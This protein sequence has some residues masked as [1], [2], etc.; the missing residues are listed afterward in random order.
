MRMVI[1][2][3]AIV[4]VT[5]PVGSASAQ[6]TVGGGAFRVEVGK[7]A[8]VSPVVTRLVC[9]DPIVEPVPTAEGMTFKGLRPGKTLCSF[10]NGV[11]VRVIVEV[12]V[13]PAAAKPGK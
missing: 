2:L 5:L 10:D 9:D 8:V 6:A 3:V 12:E 1:V 4:A 13:V 11:P 7:S